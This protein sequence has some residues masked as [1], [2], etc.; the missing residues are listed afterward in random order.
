MHQG[1]YFSRMHIGKHCSKVFPLHAWRRHP[2][3]REY[4]HIFFHLKIDGIPMERDKADAQPAAM[5]MTD[6]SPMSLPW[7]NTTPLPSFPRRLS[8]IYLLLTLFKRCDAY[9]VVNRLSLFR[10]FTIRIPSQSWKT[11]IIAFFQLIEQSLPFCWGRT[12]VFPLFRLFF[13]LWSELLDPLFIHSHNLCRKLAESVSRRFKLTCE[14]IRLV[15]FRST[16]RSIGTKRT[17]NFLIASS[18]VR[19]ECTFPMKSQLQ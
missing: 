15:C 6:L 19:M 11:N 9:Y 2:T 12:R 4:Q 7:R 18:F 5:A 13:G 10:K 16:V 17:E 3:K 1:Q 14:K 8:L